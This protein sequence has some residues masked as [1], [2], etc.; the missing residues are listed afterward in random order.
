[1]KGARRSLLRGLAPYFRP[2][3][4][5]LFAVAAYL[6]VKLATDIVIPWST[7]VLIDEVI[8]SRDVARL[9]TW[10]ALVFLSFSLGSLA[11]YRW[12][13]VSGALAVRILAELRARCIEKVHA[14]SFRY[15]N[16]TASGDL[17]ARL[18]GDVD[19]LQGLVERVLPALLFEGASLVV[20]TVVA[21]RLNVLL[22]AVVLGLGAPVFVALYFATNRRLG[23]A[24]RELQD[25]EGRLTA[26]ASEQIQ[27]QRIVKLFG[28][29]RW[30]HESFARLLASTQTAATAVVRLSALLNGG[31]NFVFHGVRFVVL[32]LGAALVVRGS[33]STGA[34]VAFFTLVGGL[35]APFVTIAEQF[36]ELGVGA[37]A[38]ARVQALL[39]AKEELQFGSVTLAPPAREIRLVQACVRHGDNPAL[40]DVSLSIPAGALVALVGPSGSGK[41]TLLGL[42]ARLY[43]PDSG[44]V[45][46]D[47]LDL[48]DAT[49]D[50][51]RS[52]IA[53]VPQTPYL[54]CIS[55]LENARLGRLTASEED[56][57]RA[58]FD[59]GLGDGSELGDRGFD[60]LAGE[61][62][63]HVSG[64]QAQRV[65]VARALIREA[66]VLLLDEATAAL[67]A[68]AELILLEHLDW[69][70]KR[71]T[72]IVFATHRPAAASRADWVFTFERGRL[73]RSQSREEFARRTLDAT[74]GLESD[75]R[76]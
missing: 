10:S 61:Q 26:L 36:V 14:L 6:L 42:L 46:W 40:V 37:G 59:A 16:E 27:N 51:L 71:G 2:H 73:V 47:E 54:F 32:A 62:G 53:V 69:L 13:V 64:G 25:R 15:H 24:S 9:G 18:T 21:L 11:A 41:S 1:M 65:A 66:D 76:A 56:V 43:D 70:K 22:A 55:V 23:E 35:I 34:V 48:R 45:R 31:T 50:S 44:A 49:R 5:Q 19:R 30:A 67:D 74:G 60:A 38:F 57:R 4:R 28:L 8:P 20:I 58:L 17:L 75:L 72:T 7:K 63:S 12:S 68:R 39:T 3:W 52:R 33:M 29:E